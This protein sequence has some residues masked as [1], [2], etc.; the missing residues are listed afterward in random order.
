MIPGS[1]EKII[2][3]YLSK[4]ASSKDLDKLIEWVKTP[5]NKLLF[6]DYLKDH[7]AIVFSVNDPDAK[8][9]KERLYIEISKT[10]RKNGKRMISVF[11]YAA[12]VSLFLSIGYYFYQK[13]FLLK[14]STENN[15][16][17]QLEDGTIKIIDDESSQ[18]VYNI[19][20]DVIGVQIGKKLSYDKE[21]DLDKLVYNTLTVP[22]G[23]RFNIVLSDGT[24]VHL[25]AGTSIKY[26]IKFIKGVK[27]QVFLNDGEA[28]F[29]VAKDKEHPFEVESNDL[30]IRVLGT[31]FNVS[32]YPEDEYIK[33]VLVEGSVGLY[34]SDSLNNEVSSTLS[35]NQEGTWDKNKKQILV[36]ETTID[37]H[38]AWIEG[39]LILDEVRFNDIL[40]KLERQ[41]DVTFANN[42]K[43]LES[44]YFTARFDV[45]GIDQVMKSLSE[46]ASFTYTINSNKI[47][48]NP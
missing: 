25:N 2:V 26:P 45:E 30:N 16:T 27:R 11:K 5:E 32:A 21:S 34:A 23:K 42:Y 31:Q 28:Y 35:P 33:T 10:K 47:I 24:S 44:R 15:I 22:Y 43:A 37:K 17:L 41:Y 3:R 13:N 4:S 40:K 20:G 36:Q 19:E 29:D 9:I 12:V 14:W 7:Y 39:R 38:V 48:I 18:E 8:A 6:K 1:I 46:A